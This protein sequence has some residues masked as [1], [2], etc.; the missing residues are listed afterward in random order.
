[1]GVAE[2]I[3]QQSGKNRVVVELPGIKDTARAK[4]IIGATATLEFKM[5][6]KITFLRALQMNIIY[7]LIQN[8]IKIKIIIQL[9]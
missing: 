6:M 8:Y 1:M 2:P 9:S 4:E 3:V 5:V 7:Q